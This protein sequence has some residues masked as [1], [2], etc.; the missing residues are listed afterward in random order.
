MLLDARP[1]QQLFMDSA[2]GGYALAAGNRG[3]GGSGGLPL[4]VPF[5]GGLDLL[6][7]GVQ[8]L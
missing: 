7:A 1:F 6:I 4:A 8:A 5:E 3:P 2:Q